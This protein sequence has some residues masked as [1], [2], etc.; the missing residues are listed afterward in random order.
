[1][2]IL[3]LNIDS[4]L[5]NIALHKIEMW[6]KL[7]GD[8][9][10]WDMP[11]M[12]GSTDRAYASC[13][14]TKNA[15]VVAN[16]K[17]LYPDLL[18]GGTGYDLT[19]VLSPEIDAMKPKINYGFT[20]R[21]CTRKC[22]F[23]I[24]PKA[25]GHIRV[26][27]DIYDIWDG[28]SKYITLLDNNILALPSHFEKICLQVAEAHIAVDFNQALDIR[29]VD[30]SIAALIAEVKHK[31]Y[32]SFSY[33]YMNIEGPFN[34]GMGH[35]RDAGIRMSKV[36]IFLLVGF[37]TTLPDD[38]KR[39]ETIK[40]YGASPFV[41]KYQEVSGVKAIIKRPKSELKELA[42]WVNQ[43]HGFYEVM[44]FADWVKIKGNEVESDIEL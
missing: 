37:N 24:V 42:R 17:G 2:K 41:M 30:S 1:M 26:V 23:C 38:L 7:K 22:P 43:P 14:F 18:A 34:R 12:L 29:L 21:G 39:I 20:T 11:I 9:V 40:G 32:I 33:D 6:H 16:Y 36:M 31:R 25:E 3:L 27:G 44:S 5:P 35:L 19:A 28:K 15:S 13:I 10:I 8:E 4:K